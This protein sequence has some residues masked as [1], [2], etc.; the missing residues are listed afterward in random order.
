MT[1]S[2]DESLVRELIDGCLK[3]RLEDQ[4]KLYRHFYSYTMSIC[5]RYAG[6]KFEAADIL[7]DGFMKVFTHLSK[8]DGQKPFHLWL[9]RIM[10]N[11]AIDY[12]RANLKYRK[13]YDLEEAHDLGEEDTVQSKLNYEDLLKLVQELPPSY[14]TVFNLFAIDGYSHEEIASMLGISVGASKSNLFK[15]RQKLQLALKASA[16]KAAE[17]RHLKVVS[18]RNS[19]PIRFNTRNYE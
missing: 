7:N 1:G 5:L 6:N 13:T 19:A 4:Q 17:S 2:T 16:D 11:T 10:M 9:R 12:Y 15:A 14:R 18:L 3:K 8:F